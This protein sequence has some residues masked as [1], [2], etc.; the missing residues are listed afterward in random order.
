MLN[1]EDFLQES[2][3]I[4]LNLEY[5]KIEEG[6]LTVKMKFTKPQT[7]KLCFLWMPCERRKLVIDPNLDVSVE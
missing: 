4:V 1:F 5:L 6:A 7:E 2:F 3:I